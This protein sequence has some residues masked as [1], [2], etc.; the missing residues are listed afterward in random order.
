MATNASPLDCHDKCKSIQYRKDVRIEELETEND[1]LR[2]KLEAAVAIADQTRS[3]ADYEHLQVKYNKLFRDH[4]TL[5]RNYQKREQWARETKQN[6]D[7]S[8]ERYKLYR[9]KHEKDKEV[10][11]VWQQYYDERKLSEA[12]KALAG[13]TS[14]SDENVDTETTPRPFTHASSTTLP[15]AGVDATYDT[16]IG[17]G[18]QLADASPTQP[19]LSVTPTVVSQRN[20]SNPTIEGGS[21]ST[22]FTSSP[23]RKHESSS[24][25]IP[26]VV[27]ARPVKRKRDRSEQAMPPPVRVKQEPESPGPL[28]DI[29]SGANSS[30]GVTYQVLPR[31]QTSDLDVVANKLVTPRKPKQR[32]M[33]LSQETRRP[34]SMTTTSSRSL[35]DGGISEELKLEPGTALTP[36]IGAL[37]TSAAYNPGFPHGSEAPVLQDLNVNVV[38]SG[39]GLLR[40]SSKKLRSSFEDPAARILMLSEGGEDELKQ[41]VRTVTNDGSQKRRLENLLEGPTPESHILAGLPTPDPVEQCARTSHSV[42]HAK[43]AL[44]KKL[45]AGPRH[46][47]ALNSDTPNKR[48]TL[49]PDSHRPPTTLRQQR[50]G[51]QDADQ[52][53]RPCGIDD[54]PGPVRPEDEPLRLRPPATLRLENFRINPK[55]MGSEYAWADTLRGRDQ[56]RCLP[57]CTKPD[58]CGGAFLKFA[59]MG[60]T[61]AQADLSDA[62]VLEAY[63]GPSWAELM[64]AY[65]PDRRKEIIMQARA[66][67]LANKFG[68]HRQAFE[69][70]STPPGFWRTDMPTTQEAEQDRAKAHEMTREKIEERRREA[71][72]E[73]G[74]WIFQDE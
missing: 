19:M 11:R 12:R 50:P 33:A 22:E 53:R 8:Y 61:T 31:H 28:I 24:D 62:A 38:L 18:D 5:R 34:P 72:R 6:A 29:S 60:S 36:R 37:V 20:L 59:E 16:A 35:S 54:S 70:R 43:D 64:G 45:S 26:V 15:R 21:D 65:P 1:E 3:A 74:R 40:K 69:R 44:T 71:L 32:R 49:T 66:A 7:Q 42:Q 51:R 13:R 9:E 67:S 63:L 30:P 52:F 68:R 55:Y 58:C 23:P 48:K 41:D 10:I 73:G 2:Q 25:S 4:Q 56:R 17:R 47:A 14:S 27:S 39:K 46:L 57:G